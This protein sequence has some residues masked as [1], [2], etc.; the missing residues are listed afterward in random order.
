[1]FRDVIMAKRFRQN[2]T[3]EFLSLTKGWRRIA[4]LSSRKILRPD[5]FLLGLSPLLEKN[6][7]LNCSIRTKASGTHHGRH[8]CGGNGVAD[9]L[10]IEA[11][12]PCDRFRQNLNAG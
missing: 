1:M 2:F 5:Q 7:D 12:R 4:K 10:A 11:T 3:A 8:V 9:L 6:F